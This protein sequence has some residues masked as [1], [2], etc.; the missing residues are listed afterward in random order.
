MLSATP[1]KARPQHSES[2][3]LLGGIATE[4]PSEAVLPV[5]A[6]TI[7]RRGGTIFAQGD[8]GVDVHVIMSGTVKLARSVPKYGEVIVAV[9]G[10]GGMLG[11]LSFVDDGLRESTAT[12]VTDVVLRTLDP[13]DLRTAVAERPEVAQ[14]MLRQLSARLRRANDTVVDLIVSDVASRLIKTLFDLGERFG[15]RSVSG[16]HVGIEFN[17][18][19]LAQMVGASRETVNKILSDFSARGWLLLEHQQII[20]LDT[21]R[22]ARHMR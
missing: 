6:T 1:V 18:T 10:V 21:V 13:E 15:R 2:R 16:L 12:A 14:A 7:V 11:E 17:Q 3:A 5:M 9:L 8:D 19:E 22:L 4:A 20:L